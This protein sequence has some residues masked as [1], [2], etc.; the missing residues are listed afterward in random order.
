MSGLILVL[1]SVFF[2]YL[3]KSGSTLLDRVEQRERIVKGTTKG[4]RKVDAEIELGASREGATTG[5]MM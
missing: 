2:A 3:A 4:E 5:L 1:G